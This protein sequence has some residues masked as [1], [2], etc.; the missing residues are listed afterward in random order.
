MITLMVTWIPEPAMRP[1]TIL[2]I[3]DIW[4]NC[5]AD[6]Q[7]RLI[8]KY[9]AQFDNGSAIEWAHYLADEF[10]ESRMARPADLMRDW[11]GDHNLRLFEYW[12]SQSSHFMDLLFIPLYRRSRPDI[13][14]LISSQ[15]CGIPIC[16]PPRPCFTRLA[17]IT[18]KIKCRVNTGGPTGNFL[19][20][21][22]H[23]YSIFSN[24][25]I[26]ER[27]QGN[28]EHESVNPTVCRN[29]LFCAFSTASVG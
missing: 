20:S 14:V 11:C 17:Q 25:S 22:F 4:V 23:D 24:Q 10:C 5:N 9:L 29:Y 8:Q 16:L 2:K 19:S 28:D 26:L 21:W 27:L 1:E 15:P 3:T 7:A 6:V 13:M 12:C 18:H